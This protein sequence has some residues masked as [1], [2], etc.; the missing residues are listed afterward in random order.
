MAKT[1]VEQTPTAEVPSGVDESWLTRGQLATKLGKSER[2]IRLLE[3]Q[4][5]PCIRLS[6][7]AVWFV[8]PEVTRWLRLRSEAVREL[9]KMSGGLHADHW[10]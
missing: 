2:Y 4:G 9:K 1:H 7:K 8:W 10:H 6:G 3:Q 5:V